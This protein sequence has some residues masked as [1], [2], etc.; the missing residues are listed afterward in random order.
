MLATSSLEAGDV[1]DTRRIDGRFDAEDRAGQAGPGGWRQPGRSCTNIGT[2]AWPFRGVL[3]LLKFDWKQCL[4]HLESELPMKQFNTW[5]RP[6][7]AEVTPGG[8]RLL[9][10]N[11]Y[12]RDRVDEHYRE[13]IRSTLEKIGGGHGCQVTVTVGT[14]GPPLATGSGVLD[15][16]RSND[17]ADHVQ[18]VGLRSKF[19]FSNFIEGRSNQ[20]AVAASLQVAETPGSYNP[21]LIYGGVGL[22]KTHLV[23]AIGNVIRKRPGTSV[24]Y[25]P[26]VDFVRDVVS[27]IRHNRME[28]FNRRYRSFNALLV[29]DIQFFAGKSKS[30]EE[31]FH[32]FDALLQGD[33]QIVLTCDRYPREVDGL[34]ERLTSRFES[35]V[36]Y[37]IEPPDMETRAA[38]LASKAAEA[39]VALPE[40]VAMFLAERLKSNVRDLEGALR[41]VI[42]G[43]KLHRR[44]VT[45][46][47][48]RE[49]LQDV[50]SIQDRLIKIES[51]QKAV[52]EYF[53]LRVSDLTSLRRTRSI[54]RPRQIAMAIARELTNRS[55][56]EI[57][58][59]FNR[60]DHT[61]VLYACRK[62]EELRKAD[63]TIETDY[64]NLMRRLRK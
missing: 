26:A 54:V 30:Q 63:S 28:E 39:G 58:A 5:V 21:L 34:P 52:S 17:A 33:H 40:D 3:E 18:V 10:P 4:T 13:Q 12:V 11:E 9:A 51:I 6:L 47:Y 22:G 55:F 44:P 19:Q 15:L 8:L 56:P 35:G 27:S 31:F 53:Q 16:D 43:A 45:V 64:R 23:H 24:A 36:S 38:I 46:D 37:G 7:Q 20:L 57:A 61:T 25:L 62:V 2:R 60:Q 50:F 41:R 59:A 14:T 49:V 29:D 32:A 1:I 42:M 48:C